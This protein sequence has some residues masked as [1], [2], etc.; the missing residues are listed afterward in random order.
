[1]PIILDTETIRLMTLFENLT[2]TNVRDCLID[3]ESNIVYFVIEK[4]EIGKAI[5]KNGNVIRKIENLI[6][7]NIKV[8]EFSED[9]ENFVKNLIPQINFAKLKTENGRLVID[10][11]VNKKDRP[12]IIGRNGK[13]LKIYKELLLRNHNIS[14][15]TVR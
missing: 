7:K 9:A 11:W 10:I 15:I 13:S 4:G 6:K 3:N 8:F 5:G 1:M 12:T 14:E 2:G